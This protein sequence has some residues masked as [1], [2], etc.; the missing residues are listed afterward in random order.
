MNI[1]RLKL[2]P[3]GA[4]SG[5]NSS[6]SSSLVAAEAST[7]NSRSSSTSHLSP[8]LPAST[9]SATSKSVSSTVASSVRFKLE[10]EILGSVSSASGATSHDNDDSLEIMEE[11]ETQDEESGSI[12]EEGGDDGTS[13]VSE[14]VVPLNVGRP[15]TAA[16]TAV[17]TGS[18]KKRQLF[19]ID[20]DEPELELGGGGGKFDID[21][22]QLSG[23]Q[24]AVHFQPE[25]GEEEEES[26]GDFGVRLANKKKLMQ[27]NHDVDSLEQILNDIESGS[28][29]VEAPA[30]VQK[31]LSPLNDDDVLINNSKV[32]LNA[33]K[34]LQKQ[35]HVHENNNSGDNSLN[36][37]NDISE[38]ARDTE[39]DRV[40]SDR[41]EGKMS[42]SEG[43]SKSVDGSTG[44]SE[45]RG[46]ED[47]PFASLGALKFEE[48]GD[49]RD[50]EDNS[51]EEIVMSNPSVVASSSVANEASSFEENVTGSEF[52][53]SKEVRGQSSPEEVGSEDL[54][55]KILTSSKSFEEVKSQH[56]LEVP[57]DK[58][59]EDDKATAV[60]QMEKVTEFKEALEDISEESEPTLTTSNHSGSKPTT[61][62]EQSRPFVVLEKGKE[63][64]RILDENIFQKQLSIGSTIYEDNKENIPDSLS[65]NKSIDFNSV[66]S[67][68]MF[69]AMQLEMK[70][71]REIIANK[72][73]DSF[74]RRESLK[75]PRPDSLKDNQRSDSNS[76]ATNSTEYRP[77]N[78]EPPAQ[79]DH[80]S[81]VYRWV[82]ILA[83]KLQESLQ[84]RD[85]LQAEVDKQAEEINQI[86]KQLTENVEAIRGRPHWMRDQESTGQRISEISIDLVS[87]TDDALSDFPD[88]YEERSNR[89]SRERQLDLNL[90]IDYS[91]Q[92]PL[93][94]PTA[95]MTKQLEQ[96]RKYLS[97]DELRLFNMVQGKFDDYINLEMHKLK[98]THEDESKVLQE[99]LEA[100]KN[101]REAEVSRL[102]QMLTNVKSG[103]T[104]IVDLRTEL[105]ARHTQ[106][107]A[108]LRTYFEKKCVELEKQYSEEVFSM[109][110]RRVSA[111]DTVS[112]IS[113]QEEFPEENGGYQS[114]HTSPKRKLKEE[115]YLSPTHH[116]IT[117][118]T[119]DTAGEGSADEVMEVVAEV[120]KDIQMNPDQLNQFYKTKI[121]DLRRKH[122]ADMKLLQERLKY[123]EDKEA[124][125]EFILNTEAPVVSAN[126]SHL[127]TQTKPPPPKTPSTT[128]TNVVTP[129]NNNINP[130]TTADAGT[131]PSDDLHE[132]ISDY[133]RRLQEQVALARQDVLRELEVQI[134]A[135]LTDT[136]VE[137]SHWPPE[138]VLLR[139]KFT[140]KSQLE[141]AQLEIKHEE[142]MA[143]VKADFEKQL[144]WK[145]K[146]Q[147]TFDSTRDLDKII[148]ERDNLR[149]LSSTLRSVLG[150]L[151]KYVTVCEDDLN[152]T[153]I[154]E[155]HKHGIAVAA[156]GDETLDGTLA[157]DLNETGASTCSTGRKLHKFTPDVSGLASIIEDPSLLHYVSKEETGRSSLNLDE[158]LERLRLE[159]VHLLKLSEKVTRKADTK[160]EDLD[161][162]SVKS[163][164]CEEEDGLKRG[165][166]SRKDGASTRSFD[167]NMVREVE[168][169]VP[170]L[171]TATSSLPTDLTTVQ[172]SGE[173]NIQLHELRNRLLKTEDEKRLLETEL[174]DTLTRHNSLVL[175]LNE[176]KQ[177][178]L[179]LNS[180]RVEF[181]EGY[182][183]N[184][185]IPCTHQPSNS[186]VEL[187]DRSKHVLS[188]ASDNTVDNAAAANLLQL[189]EDFCREGERYMDDGK[190]EK[191]DLQSQIE[192]ADKQLKATRM[193]LEEQ[194]IEREQERDEFVKEIQRLKTQLRE[195]DKDKVSFER[196]TKEEGFLCDSCSC[197][198]DNREIIVKLEAVELQSKELGAHLAERDDRIRKLEADLKDSIDKGFT[199]RE[200][201][202]E[203]ESQID[204]KS[205]NEHVLDSKIKEL[206]HYINAQNRQNESLHQEM[207]SMKTDLAVRGYDDKIAKLEEELRQSRPSVEQSLVLEALTV[208][209]RDIEETLERKT[210]NLETLHSNSAASLVCSSPSEDISMNQDSPLHLRKKS[211]ESGTGSSGGG[212]EVSQPPVALPVDEVQRIFDKLHR[213]TRV[214]EV[215][216]KR[217][218]DLE[219]QIGGVRTSYA[220]LQHERDV[221]QERMSEQSL[222]ITTLQSKLDEQRMR[223]EELHRQ[224]TSHL[225]VR[226]HDLQEEL[227]NLRETLHTRDKQIDNLK[228]FLENSRQV[229]ERQEKELAM[230]QASNDRSQF[231]IKLEAELQA[232]TDEVQQLK[233]KIQ[234][235]MIN[236]VA[237]PDLMETMLADKNDEIDQ[238]REK[239]NQLQQTPVAVATKDNDDNARTLSDIV[240]ITD[241]DESADMVM[242]RAPEQSEAGAG[243]FPPPLPHSIPMMLWT[244]FCVLTIKDVS[245]S[246]FHSKD[247]LQ[248]AATTPAGT[249]TT[250]L[251]A[252]QLPQPS[253]FAAPPP[254]Q[255]N[256]PTTFDGHFFQDLSAAFP[257]PTTSTGTPEFLPRQINFSLVDSAESRGRGVFREPA[258]IEEIREEE[259]KGGR[260]ENELE[261][262][263]LSLD[264]VTSEREGAAK[265]LQEKVDEIADLQVELGARNKMYEDLLG[266]RKELKEELERVKAALDELEPLT[267]QLEV[268]EKELRE[269]VEQLERSEKEVA[270][271]NSLRASLAEEL[272]DRTKESAELKAERE[273]SQLLLSTL[274]QQIESLNKTIGHKDELVSKLEKDILNYSKNEE[275]YL[276]QLKSLDAKETE[277]KIVQGNYKDR[278]HEIEMLNEDNRFLNEDINRLKSELA[279]SSSAGSTS[280]VSYVQFLKQNCEKFEEELRETKVLLTEKMLALERVR[281]ELTSSQHDA[282]ELKSQLKQKE[283][284]M[285]Q[286]GDDGNSL[287]EALS[288]IQSKMQDKL[289]EE[290]ERSAT[291]QAEIERLKVQLQRSD[292]SSSPKPFSV[293][294]IA[295]QL[296]KELNYS[297]QLDSSIMKAIESD[298][299]QS[300]DDAQRQPKY[301]QF[302]K[303]EDLRQQL[304]LEVDKATKLQELL[305]AE[306][307]NS[308]AIQMQ[309]AEI[310]EAMRLRLEAA[311]ENEGALQKLLSDE[312][313]KNDRLSTLVAGVQRTKSF[314]NYL[315]MKTKSSPHESPS[316]RLNRSN[317]FESEVVARLESEIKFLTAQNERE[318]ERAADSQ[319]VLERERSRFEKEISDRNEHGEQV[320]RELVRVTKEKER[321]EV[322]LDHEQEKLML[323]HREIE[324][325]EKR[326]G[327]LQES[328]SM[329]SIRR[330]R[331]SGANS[332]EFQELRAR[333]DHVEQERN[334][335]QDAV[336]SLRT[337]VERRKHREA[338]LTEALSKENSLLEAGQGT[339]V[340]EEFLTKL[341]DLNRMLESNARENHQQAETLRLMMDERKALQQRIQELERYSLHPGQYNRDDLEERANHLF[342]KY[343]RSESHRKALVHQ[344]RY[345]QIV[346]ATNEEN[347]LKALQLLTAQGL[348]P[349]PPAP[350]SPKHR[351]SFRAVVT[352]VIAIERMR[353]IVRKWQGGRRVCAK[354]IFSQQFTPRRTQSASTN[355]WA[356]SPNSHFAEYSRAAAPHSQVY[357]GHYLRLP[358]QQQLLMNGDLR[359]KLEEQYNRSNVNR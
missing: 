51:I 241:C 103:S 85:R 55:E 235:E 307:H 305:E 289:R 9:K 178:L 221:L 47:K 319:R 191:V 176:T 35:S 182:G 89:N 330:E 226:V 331:V 137:D 112:D 246:L 332:L 348:T 67:L 306:K 171:Q 44:G 110:S 269:V 164:S 204:G 285:Q 163:D 239:L 286:I 230:T 143:K 280:N 210:K 345:L 106:E 75:E 131:E 254:A 50:Q 18:S 213:H 292:N 240:S 195:K 336:Q 173:L 203:L 189:V 309:D 10:D 180:Q 169:V 315:L 116:K 100:E 248:T 70:E 206:E 205:V 86:R 352:A 165:G 279:K 26:E 207:E 5:K 184:A 114:K 351:R 134:Q 314:D 325:L 98:S 30:P 101:E 7:A 174:A 347:E 293:E 23:D 158:C 244:D 313:N 136:V 31:E 270:E 218:N 146:R 212:G 316:R 123:F 185:L 220:E 160:D 312:R 333:L 281:I 105:E 231:E 338:K 117:P 153:L 225:T 97:P 196:A 99:R 72:E 32:S 102:R 283:M 258:F 109:H 217:I 260:L 152:A 93:H 37:T 71:L 211:N 155:L 238:L 34:K 261:S 91:E 275:K 120:E 334:L 190:R 236:K 197:D 25:E 40:A 177:H 77:L 142:E 12:R 61:D 259:V 272:G 150:E 317:E 96:F 202:T 124:S 249:A 256:P 125:E 228:N 288:G 291:L 181:S 46:G 300:E 36:T 149:E 251:L 257:R 183:T 111:N 245:N 24:I 92:N 56:E 170:K 266:E 339:A 63:M 119:I 162:A 38:L 73:A 79:K 129:T 4:S 200:I 151:V 21:E 237:L 359:E 168:G 108:D 17:A 94:I 53:K 265:K 43:R 11:I 341:K 232:K 141:I 157:V 14:K 326:I 74:S 2:K 299:V 45:S 208:Q 318:R 323:A 49:D 52:D 122:D 90:D 148:S 252:P 113:D 161:K 320:K 95:P 41:S 82:E 298:D 321:L 15:K 263:K 214:E 39:S 224:G 199:L 302:N 118:T 342:G 329:R 140:A 29:G 130:T 147:S 304:Q 355:L 172:S 340:P 223:A 267:V 290:Q 271:V 64:R 193:F 198:I 337:E 350:T 357:S 255:P 138:L 233:H 186:F 262:L 8:R 346:L 22:L 6:P 33:L 310:I 66:V 273:K 353:F 328:E 128:S 322:E 68:N 247:P 335:L 343:L 3:K 227:V 83:E 192:A 188:S 20:D 159:A 156:G 54:K 253:F 145:L 179:E 69:Q 294:E 354:A 133:E 167:E 219:M 295:E 28:E 187:L 121:A 1:G 264:R 126:A 287:H 80:T 243:L 194:A 349:N 358:E 274:K 60:K 84:D 62:D 277:L 13:S 58:L 127:T 250:P 78:E 278:L 303:V 48:E 132:I 284:I 216:I 88:M 166:N 344:K 297:A 76:L 222:K 234:H 81:N 115:I 268:K 107:M 59:V 229:I 16:T 57:S 144:Q 209:L 104:E 296:E 65:L 282:E 242:R 276:E 175:E 27:Q 308:N 201:I 154:G 215:A 139:E 135:L 19:D 327:A 356:R 324:S 42:S 311:I 87:E 301:K